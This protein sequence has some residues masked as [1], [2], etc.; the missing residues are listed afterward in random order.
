[1]AM[2]LQV[3]Q[4][5]I[6]LISPVTLLSVYLASTM[7]ADSGDTDIKPRAGVTSKQVI[8]EL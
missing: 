5:Q 7:N 6:G 3:N 2:L 4:E 8:K 1:M